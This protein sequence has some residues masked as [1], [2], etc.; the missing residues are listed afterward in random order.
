[1]RLSKF[2]SQAT[3]RV[4][5]R[6]LSGLV[7]PQESYDEPVELMA[8]PVEEGK[9]YELHYEI[10]GA[11]APNSITTP[12]IRLYGGVSLTGS[13][14][15]LAPDDPNLI[16]NSTTEGEPWW[17]SDLP[18]ALLIEDGVLRL[19]IWIK[20]GADLA[21]SDPPSAPLEIEKGIVILREM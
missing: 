19:N 13:N 21:T 5:T 11:P 17:I 12:V 3:K 8:V 7:I 6:D 9:E 14:F 20:D 1:M 15:N 10:K 4:F 18:R 2:F 16:T